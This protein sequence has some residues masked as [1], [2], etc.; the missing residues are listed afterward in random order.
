MKNNKSPYV[1]HQYAL[2]LQRKNEYDLAW[3]QI[4]QAYTESKKKIFSIVNTHAII[5]FEMN[6]VNEPTSGRELDMLKKT[7]E[8]SFLTLEFCITQDVR[9]NYHVL[10]YARNAIRYFEKYGWD[11]YAEQYVN[12]ALKQ[13][14]ILLNSGEYIYQGTL[15]ELNNLQKQLDDIKKMI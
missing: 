2:F 3:K 9:V 10:T 1:R 12:S 11:N 15:K 13:L 14:S 5:M 8:K 7:I 6:I 4:D